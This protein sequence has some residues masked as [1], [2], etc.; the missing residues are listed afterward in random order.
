MSERVQETGLLGVR[1]QGSL[2]KEVE[3]KSSLAEWAGF[4]TGKDNR[5][6]FLYSQR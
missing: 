5:A 6:S 2:E 1:E 4:S 3:F